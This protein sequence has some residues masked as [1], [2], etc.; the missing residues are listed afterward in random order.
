MNAKEYLGQAYRMEQRVQSKMD[1]IAALRSM[2]TCVTTCIGREPVSHTRNNTAMQDTV[3]RIME[4][5][6]ELN[7]EIDALVDLK[8]EIKQTIDQVPDV[9]LRLVLEKRDLC[10]QK[11]EQI[12]LDMYY[13]LRSV[14]EKHREAVR[15]VQ[16]ILDER[17]REDERQ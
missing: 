1:Q 4:A 16:Q 13:S 17:V 15:I 2:A 8:R 3:G 7:E 9:T 10:F 11:W 5:E 6:Q 14:Q 12:A